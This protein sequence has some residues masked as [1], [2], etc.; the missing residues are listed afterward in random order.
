MTERDLAVVGEEYPLPPTRAMLSKLVSM[1]QMGLFLLPFL[2]GRIEAV[3]N[4]PFYQAFE[5]RKFM[6]LIGG[7][8]L[9]NMIQSQVSAIGAFEVYLDGR[10]VFSKLAMGRMPSAHELITHL[11]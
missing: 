10:L 2:V 8:F 6:F 7:Y 3:R 1:L 11:R 9:L 4:H 5:Q